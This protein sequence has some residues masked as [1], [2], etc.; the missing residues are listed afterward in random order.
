MA[1]EETLPEWKARDGYR[2]PK[3]VSQQDQISLMLENYTPPD[4]EQDYE[5]DDAVEEKTKLEAKPKKKEASRVEEEDEEDYEDDEEELEEYDDDEEEEE[6]ES[7][8]DPT[9]RA[10]MEQNAMLMKQVQSL[11][12]DRSSE[13]R[14]EKED[15][16][17]QQPDVA[18]DD[19][20][21]EE[22]YEQA[23]EDPK[24]FLQ[25]IN[26]ASNATAQAIL[27]QIPKI[28]A[29]SLNR[30]T[31]VK[32]A[33]D[34]FYKAHPRLQ[35]SRTL[36]QVLYT[37][38]SGEHPDWDISKTLQEVANRAYKELNI[39]RSA[40]EVESSRK[41]KGEKQGGRSRKPSFA[42]KPSGRSKSGR[43]EREVDPDDQQAQIDHMVSQRLGG[44]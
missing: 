17:P 12:T 43:R 37:K 2:P 13:G 26:R 36:V 18:L 29:S 30:Q 40:K 7:P 35:D 27:Q 15:P 25:I 34:G 33:A 16:T 14:K 42:N 21:T 19:L 5:E 38:V 22:E 41:R 9:V 6:E 32:T 10:L 31:Q 28:I 8:I 4:D 1:K 24:I 3:E 23:L 44:R 11:L 20:F 39:K